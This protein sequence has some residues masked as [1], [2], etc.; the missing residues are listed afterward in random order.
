MGEAAKPWDPLPAPGRPRAD[1]GDQRRPPQREGA[2]RKGSDSREARREM[3]A[4]E[5]KVRGSG[6]DAQSAARQRLERLIG[7]RTRQRAFPE[8]PRNYRGRA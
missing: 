4:S 8:S 5:A 1:S 6:S 7:S 3:G 2:G